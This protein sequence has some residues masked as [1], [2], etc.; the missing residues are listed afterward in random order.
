LPFGTW[1]VGP[2]EACEFSFLPAKRSLRSAEFVFSEVCPKAFKGQKHNIYCHI[3]AVVLQTN[4]N[5][6]Q[7]LYPS[8]LSKSYFVFRICAF[9]FAQFDPQAL[10][11]FATHQIPTQPSCTQN[12]SRSPT[13]YMRVILQA[14][15]TLCR[16][17]HLSQDKEI[18]ASIRL[19]ERQILQS[20]LPPA[21]LPEELA[22]LQNHTSD[23]PSI[24]FSATCATNFQATNLVAIR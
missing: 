24:I 18:P 7:T 3:V 16:T 11:S 4:H 9:S 20:L 2:A 17:K 5:L 8:Y 14:S 13:R 15:A 23:S 10:S 21:F 12:L 6:P 19:D 1:C 22:H